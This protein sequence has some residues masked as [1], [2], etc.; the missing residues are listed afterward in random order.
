VNFAIYCLDK[1]DQAD[2]R[3]QT[4]PAHLD[5]LNANLD[6]LVTSGPVLSDDGEH[7][8][9]SLLLM[10]FASLAEAKAFAAKDPY[11]QAGLFESVDIRP[12]RKVFPAD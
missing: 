4:R 3:A 1:K 10:S 11:A 9:G 12:W 6:K 8:I 2:L 7:P 5:Y